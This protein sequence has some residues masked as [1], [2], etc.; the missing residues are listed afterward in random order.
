MDRLHRA[1]EFE[2]KSLVGREATA[3]AKGFTSTPKSID[4]TDSAGTPF[5]N[6]TRVVSQRVYPQMA[7][8]ED[9]ADGN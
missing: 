1:L 4:Q 7:A 6:F 9:E 5:A 8:L 3:K 2:D